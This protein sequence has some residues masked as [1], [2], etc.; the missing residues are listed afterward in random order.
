VCVYRSRLLYAPIGWKEEKRK[1]FRSYLSARLFL[2]SRKSFLVSL[3]CKSLLY[4]CIVFLIIGRPAQSA[5]E[6]HTQRKGRRYIYIYTYIYFSWWWRICNST[7]S[8]D[9]IYKCRPFCV[10][11]GSVG[12]V[13]LFLKKERNRP[14]RQFP[15]GWEEKSRHWWLYRGE[16]ENEWIASY[17]PTSIYTCQNHLSVDDVVWMSGPRYILALFR[18]YI[19]IHPPICSKNYLRWAIVCWNCLVR[20]SRFAAYSVGREAGRRPA[21]PEESPDDLFMT[22]KTHTDSNIRIRQPEKEKK[23]K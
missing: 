18:C 20:R 22:G 4:T 6:T 9:I 1:P 15:Y 5:T 2:D 19:T 11:S 14:V 10:W 7:L 16:I 23:R 17:R 8:W 21:R 13:I 12:V 3:L